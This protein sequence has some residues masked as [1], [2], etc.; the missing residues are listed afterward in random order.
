[1][2]SLTN[3]GNASQGV[4]MLPH[5]MVGTPNAGMSTV[6]H[7]QS[8]YSNSIQSNSDCV[9]LFRDRATST[10]H[11][12]LI[13]DNSS[14]PFMNQSD[15]LTSWTDNND[16]QVKMEYD[17]IESSNSSSQKSLIQQ[18][19]DARKDDLEPEPE[20]DIIINNVVCSFSVRCHLNL[21]EI[22]L[23]GIN[24]EFRRENG[25][26]TMKLRRPHTTA[27][28]WSSGKITCTGATSEEQVRHE[29]QFIN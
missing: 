14:V 11:P 28:M 16:D 26:V 1:M 27:L 15:E 4:R 10:I 5:E 12:H 8:F 17:A 7:R 18:M 3:V 23:N 24:V 22:A 19:D 13:T 29:I 6:Q 9:Q 20:I 21:R 2:Q 25:T